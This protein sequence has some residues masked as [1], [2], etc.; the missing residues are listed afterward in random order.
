MWIKDRVVEETAAPIICI[1][2]C[3]VQEI[4]GHLK[5]ILGQLSRLIVLSIVSSPLRVTE[6][7]E[8]KNR[9]V[10]LCGGIVASV[11]E[12]VGVEEGRARGFRVWWGRNPCR[13]EG[14]GRT[15]WSA[16]KQRRRR[17]RRRVGGG[18]QGAMQRRD[19]ASWILFS[20][21]ASAAYSTPDAGAIPLRPQALPEWASPSSFRSFT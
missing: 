4:L 11:I 15:R 16:R 18:G 13:A 9:R 10:T 5:H 19:E 6:A 7:G 12:R 21:E 2:V 8:S 1:Q 17:R 3:K 20:W 14:A